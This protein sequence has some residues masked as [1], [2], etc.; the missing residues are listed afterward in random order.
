MKLS[1]KHFQEVQIQ[2]RKWVHRNRDFSYHLRYDLNNIGKVKSTDLYFN[3]TNRRWLLLES[4]LLFPEWK[5]YKIVTDLHYH[6]NKRPALR[7]GCYR[8]A[9][10]WWDRRHICNR[11][12]Y[13]LQCATHST[14]TC[15]A[16]ICSTKFHTKNLQINHRFFF[17]S[18]L[19]SDIVKILMHISPYCVIQ[20]VCRAVGDHQPIRIKIFV[21]LT[22]HNTCTIFFSFITWRRMLTLGNLEIFSRI[23]QK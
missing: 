4:F 12:M 14:F 6:L 5:N 21:Q 17:M 16:I 2:S 19:D 22:G 3:T 15:F 8:K 10:L 1:L 18:E 20:E 9:S 23:S 11:S 13:C 7:N